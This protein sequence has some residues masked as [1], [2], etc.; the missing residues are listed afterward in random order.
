[1]V[2]TLRA[3]L[4]VIVLSLVAGSVSGSASVVAGRVT[5]TTAPTLI[6]QSG[7][8]IGPALIKNMGPDAVYLGGAQVTTTTGYQ[9][10]MNE[11][12]SIT[13]GSGE[14]IYGIVASGTVI[15]HKLENRR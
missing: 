4:G 11:T 3:S 10:S 2:A 5:V 6:S 13:L 9:L 8:E 12:L 1:M 7:S 14:A 15:L